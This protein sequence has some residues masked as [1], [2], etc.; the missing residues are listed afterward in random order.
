M[1]QL[2]WSIGIGSPQTVRTWHWLHKISMGGRWSTCNFS[3]Q[4]QQF[5]FENLPLPRILNSNH[6]CD[7][8]VVTWQ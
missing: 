1:P 4:R 2:R 6:A 5:Y 8:F 3:G 7:W